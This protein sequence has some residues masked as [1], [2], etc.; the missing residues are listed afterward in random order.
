MNVVFLKTN[1][2]KA[3]FFLRKRESTLPTIRELAAGQKH[4][5]S[6]Q[7]TQHSSGRAPRHPLR[8]LDCDKMELPVT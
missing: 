3:D 7:R 5:G 2:P 4:N 8:I 6:R 1:E